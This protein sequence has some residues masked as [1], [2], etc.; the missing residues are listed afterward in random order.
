MKMKYVKILGLLAVAAAALMA[1]AGSASATTLTSPKGTTY[2]GKI[3]AVSEGH[4]VLHNPIAKIE[5]ASTVEGEVTSHGS[6]V[7]V[8]G[9]ISTLDFTNC[10]NSWHVTTVAPGFLEI[11]WTSANNGTLTSSEAKVSS[12]RF[13]ITCT[14]GTNKTDIGTVTGGK[15]ATLDIEGSIPFLEGS[16]LCGSGA[17]Q[18]T[19]SYSIDTPDELLVDP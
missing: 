17:T 19:G 3:H 15:T 5:C 10:T 6:G 14:Y 4:A 8:V 1:F 12:T 11:H 7:T 16:G 18:W 13:G 9:H 2:T